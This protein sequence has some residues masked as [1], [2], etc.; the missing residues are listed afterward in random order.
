M[1]DDTYIK[2]K[3]QM[4]SSFSLSQQELWGA[5]TVTLFLLEASP[6][7]LTPPTQVVIGCYLSLG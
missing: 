2:M 6:H 1:V 4:E 7:L 3:F 5:R